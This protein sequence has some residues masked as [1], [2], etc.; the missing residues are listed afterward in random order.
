MSLFHRQVL[1]DLQQKLNNLQANINN[2]QR[3]LGAGQQVVTSNVDGTVVNEI[4][5]IVKMIKSET[6][7][8]VQ[9]S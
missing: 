2:N 5:E 1:T 3:P 9:K 8:L 7:T 6:N 4:R